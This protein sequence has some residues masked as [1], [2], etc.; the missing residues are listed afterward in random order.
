M[1]KNISIVVITLLLALAAVFSFS[2]N[3]SALPQH[4]LDDYEQAITP[5]EPTSPLIDKGPPHV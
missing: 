4:S 5:S 1:K 3:A 2:F